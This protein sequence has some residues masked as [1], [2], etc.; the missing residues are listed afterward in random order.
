MKERPILFQPWKVKAIYDGATQTR[1][2]IRPQSGE[3]DGVPSQCKNMFDYCTGNPE[4]GQAYYWQHGGCW[5]SSYAIKYPQGIPG[6]RL[7]VRETW[8]SACGYRSDQQKRLTSAVVQTGKG[9]IIYKASEQSDIYIKW[10]PS[11]HMFRWASRLTLEITNIRV[12]RVQDI[13]EENAIAEGIQF[14]Y[15]DK[16]NGQNFYATEKEN[17][18]TYAPN[19]YT[20]FMFLWN[21]I[22]KKPKPK[23]RGGI[24]THYE[25]FPWHESSRDPRTEINGKPH[26]CYPNPWVWI[27]EFKEVKR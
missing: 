11:I 12:E 17:Y 15:R 25:S 4:L 14:I 22:N 16:Y 2:V 18:D 26:F 13:S 9:K 19:A 6:D 3:I 10:F 27:V 5:N 8:A 7:W 20:S 21:S 23:K 24:I 1:R